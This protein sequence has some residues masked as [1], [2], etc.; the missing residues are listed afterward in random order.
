MPSGNYM[1][2]I[3]YYSVKVFPRE[4]DL[5]SRM[6][7]MQEIIRTIRSLKQ[8]YLPPKARPEGNTVQSNLFIMTISQRD[9]LFIHDCKHSGTCISYLFKLT[10]G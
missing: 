10:G 3:A 5:E 6:S 2:F 7:L 9:G 4:E 1:Y 8:D